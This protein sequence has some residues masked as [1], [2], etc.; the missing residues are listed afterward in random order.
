MSLVFLG[1]RVLFFMISER[2]LNARSSVFAGD[3]SAHCAAHGRA[4]SFPER[5]LEEDLLLLQLLLLLQVLLLLQDLPLLQDLLPGGAAV[6]EG[7]W[8]QHSP[9][10]LQEGGRSVPGSASSC[11]P[12]SALTAASLS[13]DGC[14]ERFNLLLLQLPPPPRTLKNEAGGEQLHLV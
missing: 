10:A 4:P 14:S 12:L 9:A 8:S 6:P 3:K 1:Y 11:L 13:A 2:D 5:L 7:S